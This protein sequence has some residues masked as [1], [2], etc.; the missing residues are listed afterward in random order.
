MTAETAALMERGMDCLTNGLGTIDA[1]KFIAAV[2]G[3]QFDYAEWRRSCFGNM[4]AKKFHEEAIAYENANPFDGKAI[5][6]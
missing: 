5:Q 4:T 6:L 1:A 3:D 2:K